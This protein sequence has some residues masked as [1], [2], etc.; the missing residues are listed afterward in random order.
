MFITY[1]LHQNNSGEF[2]SPETKLHNTRYR[3][4][5]FSFSFNYIPFLIFSIFTTS[6]CTT[7]INFFFARR[8]PGSRSFIYPVRFLRANSSD[9]CL[10]RFFVH[11]LITST[12]IF[13]FDSLWYIREVDINRFGPWLDAATVTYNSFTWINGFLELIGIRPFA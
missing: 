5:C 9:P 8:P 7:L 4:D 13:I 11:V 2:K 1:V 6:C 3:R 12:L 10:L